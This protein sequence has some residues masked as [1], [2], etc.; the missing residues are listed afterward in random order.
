MTA[1]HLDSFSG[2]ASELPRGK[3]SPENLLRTL[4]RDPLVSVWD[5]EAAWLRNLIFDAIKAGLLESDFTQPYPWCR[6]VLTDAGRALIA[7]PGAQK[8]KPNA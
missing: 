4:A 8:E 5:M 3:R 1:I 7:T 2:D 6:Y